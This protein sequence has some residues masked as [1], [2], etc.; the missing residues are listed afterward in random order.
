[1][2][3]SITLWIIA[4][5]LTLAIAVYQRVTGPT[6]PVKD[7]ITLNGTE[8]K[9]KFDRSHGGDGD[10][11]VIVELSSNNLD[12]FLYWKRYKTNDDWSIV[13]MNKEEKTLTA[14]LPHQP[15]AG[16]LE[17]FV[18][19]SDENSEAFL[20]VKPIVTRF[21]GAVPDFILIPHI[22][23]MFAAMLLALRTAIEIFRKEPKFKTLT[24]VTV[25]VLGIGGMILGPIVQKYAFGEFWTGFPNGTDLTDNK[26]LIAFIGW[27]IALVAVIK[28]K[29]PKFWI[30]FA[31]LVMFTVFLIPH[32]VMG[33]ELDYN[34]LDKEKKQIEQMN[35]PS[36]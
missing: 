31:T 32:S 5:V 15:P 13:K 18:K 14:Y 7:S 6:H 21:K 27:L 25:I 24:I 16:K 9:A 17:Y 11:P 35:E 19:I 12:G 10:Q 36:N 26:T 1:M 3:S 2:K 28:T 30:V 34:K 33:S 4:F 8:V 29:K 22:F 20:P 23:F